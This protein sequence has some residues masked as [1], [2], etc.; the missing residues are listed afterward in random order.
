MNE[1]MEGPQSGLQASWF[2]CS[3]GSYLFSG[4]LWVL[5]VDGDLALAGT[6]GIHCEHCR[7]HHPVPHWLDTWERT[8]RG[9]GREGNRNG[10]EEV[11]KRKEKGVQMNQTADRR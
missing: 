11:E 4:A 2:Q 1:P 6:E 8:R 3:R 10:E 9:T 5:H 7:A